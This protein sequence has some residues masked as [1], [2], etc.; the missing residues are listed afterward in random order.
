MTRSP[1]DALIV[2][3]LQGYFT[4]L[5]HS[6]TLLI[7]LRICLPQQ[8]VLSLVLLI[9]CSDLELQDPQSLHLQMHLPR[10]AHCQ[11]ISNFGP[12]VILGAA[13]SYWGRPSDLW[14][15]RT[16]PSFPRCRT[17]V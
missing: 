3:V 6:L 9:V 10:A 12:L 13:A 14:H 15:V 7:V 2:V 1:A 5:K 8:E 17:S 11:Y 16:S 4:Y